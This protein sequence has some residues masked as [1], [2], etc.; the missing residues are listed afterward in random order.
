MVDGKFQIM[1][2][3]DLRDFLNEKA[4]L[5]NNPNFIESDPIQIPH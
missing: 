5:Y 4:N 1:N 2:N 3:Q